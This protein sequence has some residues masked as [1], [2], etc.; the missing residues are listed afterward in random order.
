MAPETKALTDDTGD[1]ISTR[2]KY[3]RNSATTSITAKETAFPPSKLLT[4]VKSSANVS[5]KR[6]KAT[7]CFPKKRSLSDREAFHEVEAKNVLAPSTAA[8]AIDA[9]SS[10][11][12][13]VSDKPAGDNH[14][15]KK[16]ELAGGNQVHLKGNDTLQPTS[17]S[18]SKV[19]SQSRKKPKASSSRG[20]ESDSTEW[21]TPGSKEGI[22]FAVLCYL[23]SK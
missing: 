14:G 20:E 3:N 19:K 16:I 15:A 21:G 13:H 6:E 22:A 4:A 17:D 5:L 7:E 9:K 23:K 10:K 18:Q 8:T 12:K 1:V 2:S 11:S